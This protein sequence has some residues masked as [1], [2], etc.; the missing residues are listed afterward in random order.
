MYNFCIALFSDVHKL[1]ALGALTLTLIKIL[2]V[3][4]CREMLE[5]DTHTLAVLNTFSQSF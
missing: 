5:F 4:I 2:S 1:T 3:Y